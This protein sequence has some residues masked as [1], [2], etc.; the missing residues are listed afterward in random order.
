MGRL[1]PIY[2]ALNELH[3]VGE[4][5]ARARAAELK[6]HGR[7][8]TECGVLRRPDEFGT[9]NRGKPQK[10]CKP[11]KQY[12]GDLTKAKRLGFSSLAAMRDHFAQR[13]L[14]RERAKAAKRRA[15]KLKPFVPPEPPTPEQE[16]TARLRCTTRRALDRFLEPYRLMARLCDEAALS[17]RL[18][19]SSTFGET[20][21][22]HWFTHED[23]EPFKLDVA[24][25]PGKQWTGGWPFMC[26]RHY[27]PPK[28]IRA[29]EWWP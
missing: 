29:D 16:R 4:A 26:G 6:A 14:L 8:C 21:S 22:K 2:R 15:Y 7:V 12:K 18:R 20:L 24:V 28:P 19:T 27:K 25:G 1:S 23:I 9:T 3:E 17:E 5:N 10:I 11:C 13:R